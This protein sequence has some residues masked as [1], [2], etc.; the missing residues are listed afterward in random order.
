ME[1]RVET[2]NDLKM[3]VRM[4]VQWSFSYVKAISYNWRD[5]KGCLVSNN[6]SEHNKTNDKNMCIYIYILNFARFSISCL[7][8][9]HIV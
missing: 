8:C 9:P 4:S 7:I 5:Q 2:K 1:E 3:K 6:T